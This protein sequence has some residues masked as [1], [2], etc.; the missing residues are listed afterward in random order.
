MESS[1]QPQS[2]ASRPQDPTTT[3]VMVPSTTKRKFGLWSRRANNSFGSYGSALTASTSKLGSIDEDVQNDDWEDLNDS[4][5]YSC[6]SRSLSGYDDDDVSIGSME[7]DELGDGSHYQL[8]CSFHESYN[9]GETLGKGAFG[10]VNK[11]Y[12]KDG[13]SLDG[14]L[15]VKSVAAEHYNPEEIEILEHLSDCPT[16]V[17]IKDV[18]HEQDETYIVMEE[19]Q[20]GELLER[21][22]QKLCYEEEEAKVLFRTLLETVQFCHDRGIAHCDIKP[23]N[24]LLQYKDDDTSI[25]LT[26][27]GLA[28]CFLNED[29]TKR[30]LFDMQGSAEYAAPE[31]FN[32]PED[33]TQVGYDERCDIWSCGVLLY[34][35]LAGYAPFE[36]DNADDMI[37]EVAKGK[38]KFHKRYW[39]NT[40][41]AARNLIT[42]MMRVDPEERCTL[43]EALAHP[44]LTQS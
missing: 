14:S 31:V 23:E 32:R 33:D 42:H 30:R 3:V 41:R 13:S 11:C 7:M 28:K 1:S 20:G 38:F 10:S 4:M 17:Q 22:G 39:K 9:L 44:W 37:L 8:D 21:I 34:V 15:A 2:K 24:I 6:K 18:F 16:I 5:Y 25:K 12:M 29:G 27:F 43:E 35:L 26:D 40:S 19:V 36:A